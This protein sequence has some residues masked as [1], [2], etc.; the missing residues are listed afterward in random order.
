MGEP[1]A[2]IDE[3]EK[4]LALNSNF[5]DYR[6]PVVLAFAGSQNAR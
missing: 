4:A 2:A 3:F 1:D 5:A 6:F